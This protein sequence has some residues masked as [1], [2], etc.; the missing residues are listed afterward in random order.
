V[1][2][3]LS[4]K[5]LG[6]HTAVDK[7]PKLPVKLR[8]AL[9][10]K[11]DGPVNLPD[12]DAVLSLTNRNTNNFTVIGA[13]VEP[14]P[15]SQDAT[16]SPSQAQ[17]LMAPIASIGR[18]QTEKLTVDVEVMGV[19]ARWQAIQHKQTKIFAIEQAVTQNEA[20]TAAKASQNLNVS[21]KN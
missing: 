20:I 9:T 19:G 4:F 10:I 21:I 12:G 6:K 18:G 13:S 15:G 1:K 11:N 7:N 3:K 14:G 17:F 8:F 16:I 5:L 2:L